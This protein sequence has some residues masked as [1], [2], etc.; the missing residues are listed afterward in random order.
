MN[1]S[2]AV[3]D[4]YIISVLMT[5]P[6]VEAAA[7]KIG[8]GKRTIFDRM[9]SDE[10]RAAYIN[11]KADLLRKTTA[12]LVESSLEAVETIRE[13]MHDTNAAGAVRLQAARVILENAAR[14]SEAVAKVD[15]KAVEMGRREEAEQGVIT[16]YDLK[17]MAQAL[18]G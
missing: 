3:S 14:F 9:K 15:E 12:A 16:G 10:F 13:V 2:A 17:A 1:Q 18:R 6:T 7:A 11:A 4:E 5:S 8:I